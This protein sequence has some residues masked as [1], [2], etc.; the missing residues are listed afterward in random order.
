MIEILLEQLHILLGLMILLLEKTF[1]FVFVPSS[2]W[3]VVVAGHVF[4]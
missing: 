4:L 2:V 3:L 1:P